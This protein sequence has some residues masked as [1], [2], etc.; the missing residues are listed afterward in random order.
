LFAPSYECEVIMLFGMI[1]PYLKD[2]YQIE[3]YNDQFPDCTAKLNGISV[4]IEFELKASHFKAQNHHLDPRLRNCDF[5]VCWKNDT[6]KNTLTFTDVET[7]QAVQIKIIDLSDIAR[8]LKETKGLRFIL[9]SEKQLHNISKWDRDSFLHQLEESVNNRIVNDS[10]SIFIKEILEFCENNK[11]LE[12][13]YG[14]G[15][16]ASFT[17]RIKRWGK[18]VPLGV[19]AN[20]TVW[21]NFKDAN[22]SWVYPLPELETQLRQSFNQPPT[23]YYKNLRLKD[24]EIYNKI[25]D[26]LEL[27][28]K[29]STKIKI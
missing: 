4:G 5:V 8:E 14:I 20:G 10:E 28:A 17:V 19:M 1:L 6:G 23:G 22:K 15:K 26:A 11:E 29:N 21:I 13:I 9:D 18:I 7:K 25:K 3:E 24:I 16:I 12:I 2:E 27:L